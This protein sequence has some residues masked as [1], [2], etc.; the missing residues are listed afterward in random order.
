MAHVEG[1]HSIEIP[2]S[3]LEV[4]ISEILDLQESLAAKL[5]DL[6]LELLLKLQDGIDPTNASIAKNNFEKMPS[7]H[8]LS[9]ALPKTHF[10]EVERKI[11]QRILTG[12]TSTRE[13]VQA[14][15]ETYQFRTLTSEIKVLTENFFQEKVD[16]NRE[17]N[18]PLENSLQA[19][20]EK[21]HLASFSRVVKGDFSNE[22]PLKQTLEKALLKL[23][24]FIE[25]KEAALD[26]KAPTGTK[27][28]ARCH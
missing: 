6:F 28:R 20:S 15:K 3:L 24:T 10:Q 4:E 26:K 7:L 16:E 2:S 13:S 14:L 19:K 12:S 5:N 22:K 23:E 25:Q 8:K 27:K 18:K 9:N 21:A 1:P 17:V 11:L